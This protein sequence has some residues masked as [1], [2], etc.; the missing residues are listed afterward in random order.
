MEFNFSSKV[1]RRFLIRLAIAITVLIISIE[2]ARYFIGQ[3]TDGPLVWVLALI[4][5]I[6]ML[7]IFYTY[8]MLITEQKDEFLR[9]LIIRQLIIATGIALSFATVWGFLE[10]FGLVAHIYAYYVAVAWIVGFAIGAV[11]NRFTHGAW[12]EMS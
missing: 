4:P 12:G 11:V 2:A 1:N 3:G 5:G 6:A 7:A 8:G 10:E 9:M